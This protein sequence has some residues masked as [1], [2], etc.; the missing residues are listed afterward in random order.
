MFIKFDT[1]F[2]A[3]LR[4]LGAIMIKMKYVEMART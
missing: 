1:F 2:Q 4:K 3:Y